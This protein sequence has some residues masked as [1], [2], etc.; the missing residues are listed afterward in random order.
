MIIY[1]NTLEEFRKS[2]EAGGIA[3]YIEKAFD[4][5]G[6]A[7]NNPREHAAWNNSLEAMSSVLD[8]PEIPADAKVAIEYKIPATNKRVDF[9]ISGLDDQG[10]TN[11]VIVELKQWED[12]EPSGLDGVVTYVGGGPKHVAHPCYQAKSYADIIENFN[13]EVRKEHYLFE[14]CAFL[15][16]FPEERRDHVDNPQYHKIILEAP[17]FLA[18]DR[19]KLRDFVKKY[20]R[21]SDQGKALTTIEYGKIKPSKQLQD[22]VGNMILGNKEFSLIDDQKVAFEYCR[23][24]IDEALATGVKHTLIV[25]GGAGTGKT[26]IAMCLLGQLVSVEKKNAVYVSKNAAPRN[27]YFQKMRGSNLSVGYVRNLLKGSG[28]FVDSQNNDF[29]VILSDESHRLNEKSGM[30][31]NKGENQIKEIIRASLVSVF[32][33]DED[34]KVT[35][36]DIGSRAEILKWASEEHSIL[37]EGP[38]LVLKSQF[39]CNGSDGFIAFLD[40]LL[41]GRNIPETSLADLDYDFR[42][43]DDPKRMMDGLRLLNQ[44]TGNKVR[45]VAGYCYNWVSK[46]DPLAM[47]IN[48]GDF[49][50]QWNFSSTDTWAIDENS[51]DQIGCIHTCQ[52]LEFDYVGVII[53]KDLRY[54]NGRVITDYKQRART[55]K[56][57]SGLGQREDKSIAD[58]IIRNTYK[59]LMDRGLKGCYVYCE[60]KPLRDYLRSLLPKEEVN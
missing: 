28:S 19:L 54:E 29:D 32:F 34:Q 42:V 53:G 25:Q 47:D 20:I 35:L 33:I 44:A 48:V 56:S 40:G 51:F 31:K 6:I 45:M 1:S 21:K 49:H 37:E 13:A 24:T 12:C 22:V 9:L 8:T 59:V 41:Y 23:K 2:V 46:N 50:A 5:A 36:S 58:E 18:H 10:R 55:D 52:G 43:F 3:D 57:L 38:D 4:A 26:V 27:V 39:R 60:D 7:H 15:H 30:Y 14:P 16:Y 11:V 17:I